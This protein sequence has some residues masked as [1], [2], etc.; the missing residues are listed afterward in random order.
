VNLKGTSLFFPS[1]ESKVKDVKDASFTDKQL[2]NKYLIPK[3][4]GEGYFYKLKNRSV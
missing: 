4:T 2:Q 1:D 3:V